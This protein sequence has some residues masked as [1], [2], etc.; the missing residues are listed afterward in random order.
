MEGSVKK[1]TFS[2]ALAL[3][4]SCVAF[5]GEWKGTISDEKCGKAHLDASEKSQKCVAGCIKGGKAAVFV[6]EDGK[7][8]K[9]HNQDAIKGHEGH[10]VTISGNIDGDSVHVDSVKM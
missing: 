1:L 4:L 5:A 7:V 8:L 2:L 10:K 3:S 9:I 6:T